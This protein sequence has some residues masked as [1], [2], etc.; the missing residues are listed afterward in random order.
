MCRS[1]KTLLIAYQKQKMHSTFCSE[2][3]NVHSPHEQLL[4]QPRTFS[5]LVIS[6]GSKKMLP[7]IIPQQKRNGHYEGRTRDLGVS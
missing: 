2:I 4:S 6:F 5:I 1:N 3:S 7:Y